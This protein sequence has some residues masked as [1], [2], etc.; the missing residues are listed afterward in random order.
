MV[1]EG[2]VSCTPFRAHISCLFL[3][4]ETIQRAAAP[5]ADSEVIPAEFNNLETNNW[6]TMCSGWSSTLIYACGYHENS[7]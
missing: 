3:L 7:N 2:Q 5:F 1:C 4:L 6:V